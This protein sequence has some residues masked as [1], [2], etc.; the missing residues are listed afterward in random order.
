M[1]RIQKW[2]VTCNQRKKVLQYAL[3]ELGVVTLNKAPAS[4]DPIDGVE[5][6]SIYG[7]LSRN[8]T[9]GLHL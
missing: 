4:F 9:T 7:S 8:H 5:L 6:N 2:L 3:D 1:Y